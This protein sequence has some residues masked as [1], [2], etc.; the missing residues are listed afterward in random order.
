M[1]SRRLFVLP[2]LAIGAAATAQPCG[3]QPFA[4]LWELPA[5]GAASVLAFGDIDGDG[6]N[7]MVYRIG[8]NPTSI[9][10]RFNQGG[11]DFG[12]EVTLA[13]EDTSGGNNAASDIE[14]GD[15]DNDGDLD[16]VAGLANSPSVLVL[17]NDGE[18][19]FP[20]SASF[21]AAGVRDLELG[22]LDNDGDLDVATAV[23]FNEIV[24]Y[25]NL[26]EG[27]LDPIGDTYTLGSGAS[28]LELADVDDDGDL[29]IVFPGTNPAALVVRLNS[30]NGRFPFSAQTPEDQFMGEL[31]VADLDGDGDTDAAVLKP[32]DNLVTIYHNNG[33]GVMVEGP[34]FPVIGDLDYIQA[35]DLD[36]DDDPDLAI[37]GFNGDRVHPLYNNGGA[38]DQLNP[39]LIA[40]SISSLA[41]ADID[42]DDVP[43]L[44]TSHGGTQVVTLMLGTGTGELPFDLTQDTDAAPEAVAIGDLNN[45]G[46]NDVV[47]VNRTTGAADVFLGIPPFT[48]IPVAGPALPGADARDADLADLDNDGNLDLVV[49]L[50]PNEVS[51]FLG[52]GAGGF[53][54]PDRYPGI[55]G[56]RNATIA[57]IDNDNDPDIIVAC[58]SANRVCI[59]ENTGLFSAVFTQTFLEGADAQPVSVAVGDVTGNGQPDILT[60]NQGGGSMTLFANQGGG[61]FITVVPTLVGGSPRDI[62]TGDLDQDGD[63]DAVVALATGGAG[64]GGIAL[65]LNNGSGVFSERVPLPA[66]MAPESVEL[67]DVDGDSLLDIVVANATSGDTT[68]YRSLGAGAFAPRRQLR[69]AAD[70]TDLALGNLGSDDDLDIIVASGTDDL[71]AIVPNHC[72]PVG[73]PCPADLSAP[74]G[75]LDFS[76]VLAFLTAFASGDPAADLS[77][78]AGV[79]DFSDVLA[80]LTAFGA[81]CP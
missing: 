6:D 42:G 53:S 39:V 2:V 13:V 12:G 30:G 14:L 18:G 72:A 15:M 51:V 16:I 63:L 64:F 49:T 17:L 7:D 73:D 34:S 77:A 22:D 65:M 3:N 80:F 57:D 24:V 61:V 55:T 58:F 21:G 76:D 10:A 45:N 78:P 23:G 68:L 67:G 66:G 9:V 32:L 29:D 44:G 36:D 19:D 50:N 62:A 71:I 35:V 56:A 37:A 46:V 28:S 41:S 1:P 31:A 33:A 69:G 8:D 70:A 43:D 75:V 40:S 59:L 54:P 79:F 81:G 11:G 47:V 38:F 4:G 74:Q 25:E 27:K 52:D 5:G 26:V 60:A 48:L 20:F